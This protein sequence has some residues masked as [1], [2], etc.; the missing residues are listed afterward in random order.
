M[1]RFTAL[2]TLAIAALAIIGAFLLAVFLARANVQ[3]FDNQPQFKRMSD[4]DE[5][6]IIVRN[7]SMELEVSDGEW[8]PKGNSS[9]SYEAPP[10]VNHKDTFRVHVELADGTH[11]GGDGKRVEIG[12]NDGAESFKAMFVPGAGP[13]GRLRTQVTPKGKFD[14]DQQ[15]PKLL[16]H[17]GGAAGFIESVKVD[18]KPICDALTKEKLNEIRVCSNSAQP[19]CW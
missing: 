12:F 17:T 8:K 13:G 19:I 6:P 5:A 15:N 2:Q 10:T 1:K 11:C 18:N 14:V 4:D 16:R 9:W 7:G 3:P